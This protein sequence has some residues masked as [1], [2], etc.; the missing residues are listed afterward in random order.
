M[1]AMVQVNSASFVVINADCWV[2]A[3]NLKSLQTTHTFDILTKIPV[4]QCKV[5]QG[6]WYRV[7]TGS[8]KSL[9]T[10]GICRVL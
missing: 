6:V 2:A 3:N 10:F 7:A 1:P 5:I 4:E 9:C 8:F